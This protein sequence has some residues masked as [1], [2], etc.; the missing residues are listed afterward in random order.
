MPLDEQPAGPGAGQTD[1]TALIPPSSLGDLLD[2]AVR[3]TPRRTALFFHKRRVSYRKLQE[4][5]ERIAA[6]LRRHGLNP[7]DRVAVMLPNLPQAVFAFWGVLKA[8]GVVV[9]TNPLYMEKELTHHLADSGARFLITLDM[10]WSRI[11]PLR[12]KVPLEKVFVTR[13]SEG[14]AFP[15][16]K[17]LEF[18]NRRGKSQPK[19]PFDGQAVFPWS[20]LAAG[21][22]RYSCQVENPAASLALLQ[23]T[24][25]TTGVSKG[26]M[27]T[28]YNL[29]AQAF[30]IK[31]KLEMADADY[32]HTFVAI[33]PFFHVYGLIV[34]LLVPTS[35]SASVILVPRY[36]PMDVLEIIKKRKP[37][38]FPGAPSLYISLMQQKNV[39]NY[40]LTCIHYC[41]SGSAAMPV[42]KFEEFQ[43]LTAARIIEG[44]GLTE[45]SPV[46]HL[47]PLIPP[48]GPT[49]HGSIG[50][51]IPFTEAKIVDMELGNI[52]MPVG[53]PGELVVRGPQVMLGYWN[54]PDE[55][56]GAIRNG[57]LYTGDIA[58]VDEDGFYYIVDRKKDMYIVNGY[59]VYPREIDEVLADHPKVFEAIT[60]GLP[61]GTRGETLKAFVVPKPGETPTKEEVIAHCR[62][63]LASYK[64]PR[65]VEFRSELPK[66][67][68]GKI[69]RRI[70]LNEELQK[71]AEKGASPDAQD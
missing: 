6:G 51:P 55:T 68:V 54:N 37:T 4:Q 25:G 5:A 13:I 28:H 18:K 65:R 34:C 27:L 67:A 48:K 64:V 29:T 56:A 69:L 41:V 15:Y 9:M 66:S 14:L 10:L 35:I 52:E 63:K 33:L 32:Q 24:G 8:G 70:I 47:N 7:G 46:T 42:S 23:Y 62:K 26:V 12:G 71:R 21:A 45:A 11:A 57:W 43:K 59:N 38:V 2:R 17:M 39:S 31:T 36:A 58:R 16:N 50:E 30:Q 3:D 49:R 1:Y 60:V 53:V 22:E 61:H 40:D 44:Y 20:S 19:V